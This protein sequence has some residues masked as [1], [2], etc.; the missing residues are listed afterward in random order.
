M[1]DQY[2][3]DRNDF[4]KYAI[5][6]RFEPAVS[7]LVVCWMLTPPDSSGQGAR[8]DWRERESFRG[9]DPPL[10]NELGA[11]VDRGEHSVER[12][13][14]VGLL[15]E[16]TCFYRD[17]FPSAADERKVYFDGLRAKLR[18]DDLVFFDPDNGLEPEG[19]SDSKHL[20]WEEFKNVLTVGGAR[21]SACVYQHR[22][23]KPWRETVKGNLAE[24]ASRHRRHH[25]FALW[26]PTQKDSGKR[27]SSDAAFLVAAAPDHAEPLSEAAQAVADCFESHG[28]PLRHM[29]AR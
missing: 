10:S 2:V 1:K 23:R 27:W 9:I 26:P 12:V 3:G 13:K 15:G 11:L 7:R 17:P 16:A 14:E 18:D 25:C 22:R 21:R 8:T 4:V 29:P 6:R 24:L 5:L 20:R 19:K 28:W